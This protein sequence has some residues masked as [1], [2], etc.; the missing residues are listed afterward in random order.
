MSEV[1]THPYQIYSEISNVGKNFAGKIFIVLKFFHDIIF[2][3]TLYIVF[4]YFVN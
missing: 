3:F 1:L 2:I 4:V